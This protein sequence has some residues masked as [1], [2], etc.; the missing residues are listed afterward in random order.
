MHQAH[1]AIK[2]IV[3]DLLR[4]FG[5]LDFFQRTP[6]R[7]PL[8]APIGAA[9]QHHGGC[10]AGGTKAVVLRELVDPTLQAQHAIANQLLPQVKHAAHMQRHAG[11]GICHRLRTRTHHKALAGLVA[12]GLHTLALAGEHR[13]G[14]G[15]GGLGCLLK[16]MHPQHR[17]HAQHVTQKDL[18]VGPVGLAQGRLGGL[19]GV[20]QRQALGGAGRADEA[21]LAETAHAPC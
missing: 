5:F 14:L 2:R 7:F 16:R 11:H 19:V 13:A 17:Q 8:D 20:V 18:H 15:G 9:A 3:I 1:A 21:R 12:R 10:R 4:R 6:I